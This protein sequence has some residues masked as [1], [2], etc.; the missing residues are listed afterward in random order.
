MAQVIFDF[1]S[2]IKRIV[3]LRISFDVGGVIRAEVSI[4][5]LDQDVIVYSNLA[6]E[7]LNLPQRLPKLFNIVI[8][9]ASTGGQGIV[10][11]AHQSAVEITGASRLEELLELFL[12]R[13]SMIF[14]LD[15]SVYVTFDAY[16][17]CSTGYLLS[18]IPDSS[19]D[20]LGRS[21]F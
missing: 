20:L 18:F 13:K 2:I 9:V 10:V 19:S 8:W 15:L 21:R 1:T 14:V 16:T 3:L 11:L 7:V 12:S 6:L 4:E 5:S 17:K